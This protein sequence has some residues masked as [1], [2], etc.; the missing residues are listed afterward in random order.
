MFAFESDEDKAASN[1]HKHGVSFDEALTDLR[2]HR[3]RGQRRQKSHLRAV[4]QRQALVVVHTERR[5]NVRIIGARK[6]TKNEQAIYQA[7]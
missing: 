1:R 5:N 7:G 6:A 2:R 3:P 4:E